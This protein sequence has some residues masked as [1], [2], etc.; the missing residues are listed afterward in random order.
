MYTTIEQSVDPA[1]LRPEQEATL[2]KCNTKRTFSIGNKYRGKVKV[3]NSKAASETANGL[4]KHAI[5][6]N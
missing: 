3:P 4:D 1:M 2:L 5:T 6:R